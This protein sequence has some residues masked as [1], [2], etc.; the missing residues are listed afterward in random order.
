VKDRRR[1]FSTSLH[2]RRS[3][4]RVSA[5]IDE[6]STSADDPTRLGKRTKHIIEVGVREDR[7]DGVELAVFERERVGVC[8]DE[9]LGGLAC[10]LPS[11][12]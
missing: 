12:F 8:A 3:K 2:E 5:E 4:A 9:M 1:A 11:R 10:A 6:H 7:N